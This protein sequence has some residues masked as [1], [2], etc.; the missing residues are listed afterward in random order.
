MKAFTLTI[1][2]LLGATVLAGSASAN[3]R[4]IGHGPVVVHGGAHVGRGPIVERGYGHGYVG[5]GYWNGGVWVEPG[6]IGGGYPV[7]GPEYVEPAYVGPRVVV[8]P[9]VV[10]R[11]PHFIGPVFH[12]GWHR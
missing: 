7:Y 5:R 8:E 1:A 12:R 3:P 6:Y 9:R 11:G 4:A 10:V 2:S